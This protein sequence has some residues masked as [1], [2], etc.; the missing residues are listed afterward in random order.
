M[1]KILISAIAGAIATTPMT[2]VMT[3]LHKRLPSTKKNALAPRTITKE[4]SD[5]TGIDKMMNEKGIVNA[6]MISHFSYGAISGAMATP[7]LTKV[8]NAKVIAG[9]GFGLALWGGS[10]LGWLPASGLYRNATK[11]P[12]ER[13]SLY[14]ASHLAWGAFLGLIFDA[15]ERPKTLS[16]FELSSFQEGKYFV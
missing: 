12:R 6:T 7:L 2:L 5:K 8:T 14:I 1:N 9:M 11:E 13:N 4:L 10:Y 15:F 3:Y 16:G